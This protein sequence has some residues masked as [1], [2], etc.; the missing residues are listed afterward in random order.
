MPNCFLNYTPSIG[1]DNLPELID[2]QP[3]IKNGYLTIGT[4]NRY[5]KIN[6]TVVNMWEKI[7][8]KCPTVIL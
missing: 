8:K 4:F 2:I 1:I 5:N 7:L 3:C 6:D